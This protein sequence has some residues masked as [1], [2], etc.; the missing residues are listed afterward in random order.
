M[1]RQWKISEE[2]ILREKYADTSTAQIAREI[3]CTPQ[4]VR[5]HAFTLGIKKGPMGKNT[6]VAMGKM[7]RMMELIEM[8]SHGKY[9]IEAITQRLEVCERSIDRYLSV[10]QYV[11]VI[12]ERKN[13]MYSISNCPICKQPTIT[14][15][16]E[17]G[18]H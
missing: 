16:G 17:P 5:C 6:K 2:M 14:T 7:L 13:D 4:Q 15:N 12:V 18:A 1:R 10:L 11:G 8:L 9:T 3:G